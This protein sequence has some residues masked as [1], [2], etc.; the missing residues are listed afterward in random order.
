MWDQVATQLA[1][2]FDGSAKSGSA[3]LPYLPQY[4][5]VSSAPDFSIG[6]AGDVGY[7]EPQFGPKSFS[8]VSVPGARGNDVFSPDLADWLNETGSG[9]QRPN[10]GVYGSPNLQEN[11]FYQPTYDNAGA[12]TAWNS[13][14]AEQAKALGLDPSGQYFVARQYF[15]PT[16]EQGSQDQ[17][18]AI[19][20]IDAQGNARPVQAR[21][22][23]SDSTWTAGRDLAIAA[24][25]GIGGAYLGAGAL[26]GGLGGAE[27]GAVAAGNGAFLGEGAASGIGAWDAAAGSGLGAAGGLSS[28]DAAALYGSQGY[29]AGMDIGVGGA[30][31]D[32]A[33]LTALDSAAYTNA[34]DALLPAGGAAAGGAGLS[35]GQIASGA[36]QLGGAMKSFGPLLGLGGAAAGAALAG[37]SGGDPA[38][39]IDT[40]GALDFA[41]QQY[42]DSKAMRDTVAA[43]N[44]D[45]SNAQLAQ[46][47]QQ[48]GI[49]TDLNN[50]KLDTFRPLEKQIVAD[51]TGYDTAA[52]RSDAIA[53]ATSDVNQ[54]YGQQEGQ[55]ARTLGRMGL[56]G[57][58]GR[59]GAVLADQQYAKANA[60]AGATTNAVRH[61]ED[62]GHARMMDAASL[63]KNLTSEQIAAA[64]SGVSA[65][66]AAANNATGALVATNSGVPTV[67]QG[68]QLSQQASQAQAALKA[69][70]ASGDAAAWAALGKGLGTWAGSTA[71]QNTLGGWGS[72]IYDYFN[73]P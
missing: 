45:V 22:N 65:G 48:A 8:G 67:M 27:S 14:Q 63:G 5:G 66:N 62:T 42:N 52:R 49:A 21:N 58:G 19:Y 4:S 61:V 64:N 60:L 54:A 36:G 3:L 9:V 15:N 18:D 57:G 20:Q 12:M 39:G 17:V 31:G 55:T 11:G 72:S 53:Q 16:S 25:L 59:M 44:M 46:S 2:T 33:G 34:G 50:Y 56:T 32:V 23:H 10:F 69:A 29:G 68:Y 70:A 6:F 1:P 7:G 73:Q 41:K 26:A 24:T 43:R 30:S 71:G 13:Y 51:A 37:G 47:N 28:A 40:T 35:A 38:A